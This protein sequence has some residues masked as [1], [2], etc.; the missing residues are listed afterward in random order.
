[1][2]EE[3]VSIIFAGKTSEEINKICECANVPRPTVNSWLRQDRSPRFDLLYKVAKAAGLVFL[4]IPQEDQATMFKTKPVMQLPK[5]F[6]QFNRN[7]RIE[8]LY[9]NDLAGYVE[10]DV[11]FGID[12]DGYSVEV[13][14]VNHRTEFIGKLVMW[15]ALHVKKVIGK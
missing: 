15:R 1:M 6:R 9:G 12:K 7:D 3:F 4:L 11:L 13:A 5:K 14:R 2:H 8:I 10:N